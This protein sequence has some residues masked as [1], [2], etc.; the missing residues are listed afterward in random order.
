[1][2]QKPKSALAWA[3]PDPRP[4]ESVQELDFARES[5]NKGFKEWVQEAGGIL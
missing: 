5:A 3:G 4:L 1:M 2:L